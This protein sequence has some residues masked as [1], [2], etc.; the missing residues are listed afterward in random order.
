LQSIL[1]IMQICSEGVQLVQNEE[2]IS[3][4]RV[5]ILCKRVPSVF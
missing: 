2:N 5:A 1:F 3:C 4:V